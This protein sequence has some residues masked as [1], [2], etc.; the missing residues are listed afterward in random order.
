MAPVCAWTFYVNSDDVDSDKVKQVELGGQVLFTEMLGPRNG[1]VHYCDGPAGRSLYAG[2]ESEITLAFRTNRPGGV[3]S[4]AMYR[5]AYL[6]GFGSSS[7]SYKGTELQKR[8]GEAGV[9]LEL[10]DLNRPSFAKFNYSESLAYLLERSDARPWRFVASSM[11][12]YLAARFA[13][14]HPERVDRLLLLCPAFC[15]EQRWS[16]LLGEQ[17]FQIWEKKGAFFFPDALGEPTP[18]HW[19]LIED[20]RLHPLIPEPACATRMIHG[21][22]DA[23]IPVERSREFTAARDHVSLIEVDDDHELRGSLEIIH[24]HVV[25]FLLS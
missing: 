3:E 5:Y 21:T 17:A 7:A 14:L 18:V 6:H 13:Q 10:P 2:Q 8:L 23:I 19:G 1:A 9:E 16:E 24:H 25:E 11:G 4:D 15:M 20:A 12:G 22:A